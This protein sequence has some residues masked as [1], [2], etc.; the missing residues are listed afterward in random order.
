MK[1][2]NDGNCQRCLAFL[3]DADK[4]LVEWFKKEQAKDPTL[5]TSCSIRGRKDQEAALASGNS[6]ASYGKSAHNYSPSMALDLFFIIN[7]TATWAYSKYKAIAARKPT[8][9]VWGGDFNDDG[10]LTN[11]SFKD[12]PHFEVRGWKSKV[13][14]YPN[15]NV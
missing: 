14:N 15:G 6:K 10:D 12:S 5:H 1:H 3:S 4:A 9:I 11:D 7:G 2:T 8:S 13:K